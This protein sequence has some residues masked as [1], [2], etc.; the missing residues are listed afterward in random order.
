MGSKDSEE[1]SLVEEKEATEKEAK[2]KAK[3]KSVQENGEL[4]KL[5][6]Y[7]G[8]IVKRKLILDSIRLVI[9]KTIMDDHQ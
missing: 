3:A 9:V 6:A 7:R 4:I 1:E 5:Y 8:F 2:A